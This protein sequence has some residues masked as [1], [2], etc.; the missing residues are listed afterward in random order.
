MAFIHPHFSSSLFLSKHT[1]YSLVGNS[2]NIY[3]SKVDPKNE[4]SNHAKHPCCKRAKVVADFA[5]HGEPVGGNTRVA[6][7][8]EIKVSSENKSKTEV[9]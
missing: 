3:L 1:S 4:V 9:I 7:G 5:S 2:P 8:F 6:H